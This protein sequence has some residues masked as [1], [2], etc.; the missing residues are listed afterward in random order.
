MS[1]QAQF[2]FELPRKTEQFDGSTFDSKRDGERLTA[3]LDRVRDL[4]LDGQWR[5]LLAIKE[6]VKAASEAGVSARLRDLRKVRFGGYNVEREYV[7]DG[8]YKYRINLEAK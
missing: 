3:E 6:Y 5:T 2:D 8:L 7:G 4:M 1:A